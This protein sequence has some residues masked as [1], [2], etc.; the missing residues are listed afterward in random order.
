LMY[1]IVAAKSGAERPIQVYKKRAAMNPQEKRVMTGT[2]LALLLVTL[3]A[4]GVAAVTRHIAI[5]AVPFAISVL[6]ITIVFEA[7]SNRADRRADTLKGL[8]DPDRLK[9]PAD[10]TLND[11]VLWR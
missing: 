10:L 8:L 1:L 9:L 11:V 2:T 6:V 4:C 3:I 5:G 7:L